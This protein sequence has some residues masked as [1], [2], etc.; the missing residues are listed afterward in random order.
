M[1]E[2]AIE[3]PTRYILLDEIRSPVDQIVEVDRLLGGQELFILFPDVPVDGKEACGAFRVPAVAAPCGQL[4]VAQTRSLRVGQERR[5][6]T[7]Q[8]GDLPAGQFLPVDSLQLDTD[9]LESGVEALPQR[10][11]RLLPAVRLNQPGSVLLVNPTLPG[12]PVCV[13]SPSQ[14]R[15]ARCT[16]RSQ[17]DRSP[18]GTGSVVSLRCP[19]CRAVRTGTV[20]RAR[21]DCWRSPVPLSSLPSLR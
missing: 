21:S 19:P 14:W 18:V 11:V 5:Q 20:R 13:V 2:P 1:F 17:A 15:I 8:C 16:R 3:P 7:A 4:S 12:D 10:P 9:G 6:Q